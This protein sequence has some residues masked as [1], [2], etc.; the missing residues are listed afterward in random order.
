VQ[1]TEGVGGGVVAIAVNQDNSL[2][3]VATSSGLKVLRYTDL[4]AIATFRMSES[5]CGCAI[6]PNGRFIVTGGMTGR[7]HLFKLQ[8]YD[9]NVGCSDY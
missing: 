2:I 7:L 3:V 8:C 5:L 1:A 4:A 9:K 6:S